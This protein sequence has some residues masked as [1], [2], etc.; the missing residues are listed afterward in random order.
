HKLED[1]EDQEQ[2]LKPELK[3]QVQERKQE[4]SMSCDNEEQDNEP[5]SQFQNDGSL[6]SDS[7]TTKKIGERPNAASPAL[8]KEQNRAAQRAFRDRKERHLQQLENMIRDLKEQQFHITAHFQ[9]EVKQLKIH[10]DTTVTE[11]HYLREVI[12]AFETTLSRGGYVAV[13]QDVKQELYRRQQ[14]KQIQK[15]R[16]SQESSC[17]HNSHFPQ[18]PQA[19]G[20]TESFVEPIPALCPKG[21]PHPLTLSLSKADPSH[22]M[23]K[24]TVNRE[25]LYKP[26]PLFVTVASEDGQVV[27]VKSPLEPV[28]VLRPSYASPGTY[29]PKHTDYTK[30]P[31][32][33]DELQ[34]SLFPPGTLQSLVRSSMATPQE[35]VNDST[36]LDQWHQQARDEPIGSRLR[37][38]VSSLGLN[39]N[40]RLQ[41]EFDIL[42]SSPPAVDPNI[43]PEIYELPH[44]A[45]IDLVPCPKLRAQMILH[46]NKYDMDELFQLLAK[47]A[48]CHGHALDVSSWELPD[49]F[50][51]KFGFLM[52]LDME[53]IRRKVWPR[54]PPQENEMTE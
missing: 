35:V 32:V 8:R 43:S 22:E 7:K 30:H 45:R 33:F 19:Q 36:M 10:L 46:Q 4:Q 15:Q 37:A 52:G 9:R 21:P 44:D 11:N 16:G 34:S 18:V 14:E 38:F 53:R 24:Y 27:A 26:P 17:S 3:Q 6:S 41:K 31:T 25:I 47:G 51:D 5:S 23:G 1:Q 39:G 48:I 2:D 28:S 50:F 12:F 29:L 42:V 54:K 13:L 40:H 49:E 20:H